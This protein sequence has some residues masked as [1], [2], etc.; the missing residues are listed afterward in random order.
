MQYSFR[1]CVIP[2]PSLVINVMMMSFAVV[3]IVVSVAHTRRVSS[4]ATLKVAGTDNTAEQ[5]K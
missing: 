4:S 1:Q 5:K 2:V 3:V